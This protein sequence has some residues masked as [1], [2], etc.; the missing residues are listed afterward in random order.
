MASN[1][2]TGFIPLFDDVFDGDVVVPAELVL[3]LLT[4]INADDEFVPDLTLSAQV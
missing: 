1:T 2:T 4:V 3:K